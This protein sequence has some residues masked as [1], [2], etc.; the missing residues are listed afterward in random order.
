MTDHSSGSVGRDV[1][2]A[3]LV[4]PADIA[5]TPAFTR[6]TGAPV[7][8]DSTRLG[9]LTTL[10]STASDNVLPRKSLTI[11]TQYSLLKRNPDNPGPKG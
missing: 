9:C 6:V 4:L 2:L 5:V 1:M 11:L 8:Y 3:N 7:D 10:M